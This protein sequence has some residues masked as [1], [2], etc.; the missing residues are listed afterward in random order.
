MTLADAQYR[1]LYFHMFVKPHLWG[2][3][4]GNPWWLRANRIECK[5]S[6]AVNEIIS[7]AKLMRYLYHY[8]CFEH[9]SD[10]HFSQ[11]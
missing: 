2:L 8:Y 10:R 11:T 4:L 7:A 9:M 3:L 1:G 5:E 6:K